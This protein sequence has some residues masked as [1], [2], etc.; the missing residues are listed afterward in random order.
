MIRAILFIG[1]LLAG[2][3]V[4]AQFHFGFKTGLNFSQIDGPSEKDD[5]GK[6]L[7]DWSSSTGFLVG[8]SFAYQFNEYFSVRSELMYSKKG[9][10]YEFDG[11]SYRFFRDNQT[12]VLSFG[13]SRYS[14]RVS[15]SY[16]DMPV[17]AAG[18]WK[19]LELAGGFYAAALVQSIG[20]GSLTYTQ[21]RTAVLN[22]PIDSIRYT[23]DYNYK[24]DGPGGADF[25]G[26]FTVRVDNRD[27][28]QP[29]TVGAYFDQ[30]E[31]NGPL[32][33]PFDFGLIGELS[34][35]LTETLYLSGRIQYG[36]T[37]ITRNEADLSKV[38]VSDDNSLLYR[39]DKHRNFTIQAC[40]GFSF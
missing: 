6:D 37:D 20:E 4:Y 28:T 3:G 9:T 2:H 17:M 15:N 11:Q 10:E 24:K 8:M 23:L 22:N 33:A 36:L 40:L 12:N 1:F 39:D 16:I 38:R 35:F 30:T 32:Y 26:T 27:V 13:Q 18:K 29:Q 25:G 5:A 31:D 14:L 19:R 34:F 7:E 21:G